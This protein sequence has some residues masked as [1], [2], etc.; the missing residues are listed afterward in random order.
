[1]YIVHG[2]KPGVKLYLNQ[3]EEEE[4]SEF[5]VTVGKIGFGK[6]H[7]KQI[8]KNI[9]EKVAIEKE[10]IR[11]DRISD[12]WFESFVKRHLDFSSQKGDCTSQTLMKAM[13][14]RHAC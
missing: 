7:I 1:M 6:T 2:T 10:I 3:A 5:I 9:V 14:N 11:K 12:G 8:K 13:D 4:L